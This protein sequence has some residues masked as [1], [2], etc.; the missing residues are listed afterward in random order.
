MN[1][2][3]TF[4]KL[5]E[6]TIPFGNEVELEPLLPSGWKKD[7]VGNYYYQIGNSTTLFTSHLDVAS[8]KKEKVNHII[9]GNII[10]T[11]GT[12]I[13]GGDNK[14]GC[15]ILFYLILSKVP[16]TYYFFL[17]E[18]SAV[19]KNYPFG[20]LMVIEKNPD[21]FKNFRRAIAFDRKQTGELITRQFGYNCC[22]DEF[23]SALISEFQ[24]QGV[25]YKKDKTGYYTDSAFFGGLIPEITNLSCGVWN[26]HTTNEYVDISYIEKVAE[27]AS[28]VDWEKLPTIRKVVTNTT[29]PRSDDQPNETSRDGELFR[30]IFH[31][32]DELYFV[33]REIRNY[34]NFLNHFQSG[35]KYH[36][37]EW[38]GDTEFTVEVQ[39]EVIKLNDG[40]NN[41]L[42]QTMDEFKKFLGIEKLQREDFF[43]LIF[44]KFK[45][46]SNRLS[47]AEFDNLVYLKG[48]SVKKL[49]KDLL[50][51][52]YKLNRIGKGYEITKESTIYIKL[53]KKFTGR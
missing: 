43:K 15:C 46:S 6:W 12:T 28:K 30:D 51:K 53:F 36:F 35:R 5:T 17:G 44:N 39:D 37:S 11:D 1:F 47:I 38:H 34:K 41:Y 22:S 18:E 19:H 52:G 21:F 32:F 27:A 3:K 45:T 26:E 7:S 50:K 14:A 31:I 42:F 2:K 49:R 29:D 40:K 9:D 10:K 20:S 33:C 4:L 13:L 16:G 24:K 8:D 48:G 25:E 23:A